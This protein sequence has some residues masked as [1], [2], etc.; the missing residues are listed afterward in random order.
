MR[1]TGFYGQLTA[2]QGE[3]NWTGTCSPC[4]PIEHGTGAI[5]CT[6]ASDSKV[7]DA[8]KFTCDKSYL[9]NQTGTADV[10]Q[11]KAFLGRGRRGDT[12]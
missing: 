3:G 2:P 9:P 7:V 5:Y 4:T 12:C 8:T 10:C 1:V 11:G 6:S